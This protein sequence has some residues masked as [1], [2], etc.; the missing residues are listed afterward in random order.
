MRLWPR[1][2]ELLPEVHF[3]RH[4]IGVIPPIRN[5]HAEFVISTGASYQYRPLEALTQNIVAGGAASALDLQVPQSSS[6]TIDGVDQARIECDV[7]GQVAGENYTLTYWH[8][9][10]P[11]Q[12]SVRLNAS[13]A[14]V[15]VVNV[16]GPISVDSSHG[17]VALIDNTSAI[18]A[19]ATEGGHIVWSGFGT[20]TDLRAD[21]GIDLNLRYKALVLPC[22]TACANGDV[23]LRLSEP[24]YFAIGIYARDRQHL[25]NRTSARIDLLGPLE[26]GYSTF[27]R[28]TRH[29]IVLGSVEGSVLIEPGSE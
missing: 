21:L 24:C 8:I 27:E 25:V 18:S 4:G 19:T 12:H 6:V 15:E 3:R 14:C 29:E 2:R 11:R 9:R 16:D 17:R 10:L 13:Y 26:N 22:V 23:R 20:E 1:R 28:T 7:Y 5:A